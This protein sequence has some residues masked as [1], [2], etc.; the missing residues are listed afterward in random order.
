MAETPMPYYISEKMYA[1]NSTGCLVW[2]FMFYYFKGFAIFIIDLFVSEICCTLLGLIT[3]KTGIT[4]INTIMFVCKL[5]EKMWG[6]DKYV[7]WK[8]TDFLENVLTSQA[9]L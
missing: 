9:A 6:V 8:C 4:F 5:Y 3:S 7:F 2:H 1:L